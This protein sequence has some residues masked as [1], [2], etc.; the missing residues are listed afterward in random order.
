[1]VLP[2]FHRIVLPLAQDA[3]TTLG[4]ALT[5]IQQAADQAAPLE[6]DVQQRMPRRLQAAVPSM[7]SPRD[8]FMFGASVNTDVCVSRVA[9]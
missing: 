4:D 7:P 8:P 2:T 6:V 5:T 9:Y 1:M 3:A